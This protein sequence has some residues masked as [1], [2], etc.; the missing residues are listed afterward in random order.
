MAKSNHNECD[1][2]LNDILEAAYAAPASCDKPKMWTYCQTC[3]V[4]GYYAW[5]PKTINMKELDES[6]CPVGRSTCN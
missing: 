1:R 3:T 4:V 5:C 6:G 2:D